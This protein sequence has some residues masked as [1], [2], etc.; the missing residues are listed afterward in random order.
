M[1]FDHAAPFFRI[2]F[3]GRPEFTTLSF[4]LQK[5]YMDCVSSDGA[6]FIGYA[7]HL[8][9]NALNVKFLSRLTLRDSEL[10]TESALKGFTAPLQNGSQIEWKNDE[11]HLA[12]RW[13]NA[14]PCEPKTLLDTATG[15]VVWHCWAQNADARIELGSGPQIHGRGYV[16][17]LHLTLPPWKLPIEQ[18]TWGRFLSDHDSLIWIEWNGPQRLKFALLN[19]VEQRD[20]HV[21]SERVRVPTAE[22]E[23][24]SPKVIRQGTIAQ[25]VLGA[26]G[27]TASLF[28]D[29]ILNLHESKSFSQA[30]LRA[31]DGSTSSG[32]AIHEVVRWP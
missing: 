17:R 20:L 32:W 9:W 30:E 18:L 19:G 14:K 10:L 21:R 26:L 16:E 27:S 1:R 11:L 29:S 12:C 28:P 7:A 23:F 13:S 5:W 8:K 2:S 31:D 3:K 6:L 15:Q 24:Q 22:L 25:S 4:D